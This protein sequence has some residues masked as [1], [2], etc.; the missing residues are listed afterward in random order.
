MQLHNIQPKHQRQRKHVR[1]G[2]GGKRGTTSGH[3]TKGQKSR[4]GHRIRPAVRDLIQRTPKL[5]G[6]S[7]KPKSDKPAILNVSD[8]ERLGLAIITLASLK[9][10]GVIS[11]REL[12]V[13]ILGDGKLT[14]Q[15]TVEDLITSKVAKKKIEAAGGSVTLRNTK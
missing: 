10:A 13:K 9:Q 11:V 1:V 5:R 7:N 4:S 12:R 15:V 14:K 6:Y 2:R 3:G 8:L